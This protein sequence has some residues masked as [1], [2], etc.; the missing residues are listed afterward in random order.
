MKD[1]QAMSF[2]LTD[3]ARVLLRDMAEEDGISMT[4]FLENILRAISK[5]RAKKGK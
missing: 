4:A 5:E 2:R 3:K 1:K